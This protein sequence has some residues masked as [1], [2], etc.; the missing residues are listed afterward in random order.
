MPIP[1]PFAKPWPSGPVVTSTPGVSRFS[2]WP[3][4]L[5]PHWRNCF[6]I[7]DLEPEAGE[8]E[9]RVEQDRRVSGREHEPIAVG[10][11][12]IGRVVLHDPRPEHVGERRE[13]HRRAG[14]AGVRTLRSVHREPANDVDAELFDVGDR[15]GHPLS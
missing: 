3:G 13:R 15:H 4:V 10:P 2:G 9:H 8:A 11:E 1:T 7:V 5:L 12:G 6:E 14:V